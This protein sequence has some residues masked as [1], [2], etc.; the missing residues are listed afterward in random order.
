M[1]RVGP[2]DLALM[3]WQVKDDLLTLLHGI[4]DE[5]PLEGQLRLVIKDLR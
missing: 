3:G 1:D 2:G 5:L 4:D